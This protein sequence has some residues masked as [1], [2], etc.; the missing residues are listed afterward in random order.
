MRKIYAEEL[1]RLAEIEKQVNPAHKVTVQFPDGE[2]REVPALEFWE[3][4]DEWG[5]RRTEK[6]ME[7]CAYVKGLSPL[8]F[9]M[10]LMDDEILR[11]RDG[12]DESDIRLRERGRNTLLRVFFGDAAAQQIIN[13]EERQKGNKDE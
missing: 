10:L 2:M 12:R 5:S 8:L 3:H 4:R 6:G 11:E 7:Y 13:A 1:K 9:S